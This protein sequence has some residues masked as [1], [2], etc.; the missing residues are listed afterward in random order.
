MFTEYDVGNVGIGPGTGAGAGAG[1]VCG[2]LSF[3]KDAIWTVNH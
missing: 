2:D 3:T 1:G